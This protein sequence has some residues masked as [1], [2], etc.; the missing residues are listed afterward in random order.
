LLRIEFDQ[1]EPLVIA[2][3]ARW[4]SS[5]T[6]GTGWQGASFEEEQRLVAGERTR[7]GGHGAV[8]RDHRAGRA[9][10]A[11]TDAAPRVWRGEEGPARDGLRLRLGLSEF[12]VNGRKIGDAVLSPALSDYTKRAFYVTYDVTRQLKPG[13]NAVGVILGNGRFYAPRSTVPTGTVSYGLP[14][15]LFQMRV[16]YVDGTSAEIVSDES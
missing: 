8:G 6:G 2:T 5:R 14:K 9:P 15:L 7:P 10:A 3:D 16:E 12:Y 4:K 11:R 13:K 1:G